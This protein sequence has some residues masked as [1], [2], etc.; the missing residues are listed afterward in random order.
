MKNSLLLKRNSKNYCS[1]ADKFNIIMMG[2]AKVGKT[3][4]LKALSKNR[5]YNFKSIYIDNNYRKTTKFK[6][7][8][9]KFKS[10]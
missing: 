8:K 10:R 7:N 5:F 6:F 4:I 9:R 1:F 2:E 3:D